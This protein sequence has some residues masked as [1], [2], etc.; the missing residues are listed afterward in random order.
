MNEARREFQ[1]KK[2]D[3]ASSSQASPEFKN[4][5]TARSGTSRDAR[6][7]RSYCDS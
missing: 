6:K 1:S 7:I 2:P 3:G 4:I 5:Y